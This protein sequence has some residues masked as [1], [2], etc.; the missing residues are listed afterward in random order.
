MFWISP[1]F[2]SCPEYLH[3]EVPRTDAWPSSL[4]VKD[5]LLALSP[6]AEPRET[7]RRFVDFLGSPVQYLGF[8]TMA[9]IQLMI[10]E[11]VFY[12]EV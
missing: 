2:P 10:S 1:R 9:F 6:E 4:N 7:A 3:R 8:K 12:A 11:S 5:Q